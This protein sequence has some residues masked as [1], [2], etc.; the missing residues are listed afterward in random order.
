MQHGVLI[1]LL[2]PCMWSKF[3]HTMSEQNLPPLEGWSVD[4]AL[5][6]DQTN[7]VQ[8]VGICCIGRFQNKL[9]YKNKVVKSLVF[10]CMQHQTSSDQLSKTLLKHQQYTHKINLDLPT[11]SSEQADEK[12]KQQSSRLHTFKRK[13]STN[14]THIQQLN[15]PKINAHTFHEFIT[16]YCV[17]G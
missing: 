12:V 9:Q 7:S 17:K 2:L 5:G 13:R 14:L 16:T 1:L 15:L 8:K 4:T 11:D 10:W 3:E 6:H